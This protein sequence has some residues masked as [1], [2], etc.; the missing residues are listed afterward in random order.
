MAHILKKK[1]FYF[2]ELERF[3]RE[4]KGHYILH[5][6]TYSSGGY[7]LEGLHDG[8]LGSNYVVIDS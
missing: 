7:P 2:V 6:L 4:P 3:M 1:L 8:L 5:P